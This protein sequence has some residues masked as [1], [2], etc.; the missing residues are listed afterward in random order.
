MTGD[1]EPRGI[2]VSENKKLISITKQAVLGNNFGRFALVPTFSPL[3]VCSDAFYLHKSGVPVVSL[4]SPPLYIYDVDDTLDKVAVDQLNP[5]AS[6][7]IDIVAGADAMPSEEIVRTSCILSHRIGYYWWLAG[8]A[9][10][11]V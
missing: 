4:I 10:R 9:D 11:D 6:L 8:K 7:L 2:F 3:G 5:T 1:I